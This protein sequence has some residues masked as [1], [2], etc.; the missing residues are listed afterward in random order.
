MKGGTKIWFYYISTLNTC[1]FTTLWNEIEV[2][3]KH[4]A[5]LF[6]KE[7]S[8]VRQS[9]LQA[10]VAP[11]LSGKQ[12]FSWKGQ[13]TDTLQSLRRCYSAGISLKMNNAN[14]ALG[15]QLPALVTKHRVWVFP[16]L[17]NLYLLYDLSG[18]PMPKVFLMRLAVIFTA[19]CLLNLYNEVC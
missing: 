11:S 10:K 2:H 4:K 3:L 12:H 7:K 5:Q 15:E 19:L 14:P 17:G 13:L 8:L 16:N 1:L 9:E 18:F 6:L